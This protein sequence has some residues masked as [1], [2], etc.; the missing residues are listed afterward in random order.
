[1]KLC[2]ACLLGICCK[3]DGRSNTNQ[4]ILDLAKTEVL[5]PVCPEQLGGLPIPRGPF[6]QKDNHVVDD[7]GNDC[8][9]N[10]QF[11]AQEVLR[12]AKIYHIKEAIF[13][14]RSPSCGVGQIYDGSFSRAVIEGDGV[15]TKL[16]KKNGIKVL[17]EEEIE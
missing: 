4:K 9:E 6:E 16:L 7:Q 12:I 2:S 1:M 10:F 15:T 3:Y 14:Q 8:T 17:S 13:K 11:G 5:I